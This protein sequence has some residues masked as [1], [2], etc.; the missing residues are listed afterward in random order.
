MAPRK[1]PVVER[2]WARVQKSGDG[3]WLWV[4]SIARGGYGQITGDSKAQNLRTHRLSWELHCGAIPDGL[5]VCHRCDTP[6]CVNPDH[7]F[8]GT[9]ADNIADKVSK[10]R[11]ARGRT[12]WRGAQTHCERGHPFDL[13]NTMVFKDGGRR[14]RSCH[15]A[16]TRRA[17]QRARTKA[18][19]EASTGDLT[20]WAPSLHAEARP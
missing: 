15:N 11:Q 10:K 12:H 1:Q 3:C 4:G 20:S 16:S 6:A 18:A 19:S 5:V 17:K 13:F 8:L 9:H 2:F 7:L 14:C